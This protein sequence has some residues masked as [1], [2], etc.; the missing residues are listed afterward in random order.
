MGGGGM[1]AVALERVRMALAEVGYGYPEAL[2]PRSHDHAKFDPRIPSEV[3]WKA[4]EVA[5]FGGPFCLACFLVA[6]DG[7][8]PEAAARAI[9]DACRAGERFAED[10]GVDR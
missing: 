7:R 5:G 2:S 4:R 3:M 10:C 6:S 1:S 9:R 8:L